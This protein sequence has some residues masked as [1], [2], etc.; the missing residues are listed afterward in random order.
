MCFVGLELT[1]FSI[2]RESQ[3]VLQS[4]TEVSLEQELARRIEAPWRSGDGRRELTMFLA[5]VPIAR[6]AREQQPQHVLHS[7]LV[8]GLHHACLNWKTS[9]RASASTPVSCVESVDLD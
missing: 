2:F 5:R 3:F 8:L 1:S 7:R 6:C 9:I 4:Y